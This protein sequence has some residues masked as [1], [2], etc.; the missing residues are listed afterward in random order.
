M[1]GSDR[2]ALRFGTYRTP[3]FRYGTVVMCEVRGEVTIVGLTNSRIP[4]PIGKRVRAKSHAVFGGLASAIHCESATAICYWFGVTPQTVTK[5]RKAMGVGPVNAGTSELKRRNWEEDWALAARRKALSKARDPERRR[6]IAESKRGKPR[7]RHVIEAMTA[8]R[9]GVPLSAAT[10][11][12]L[13][14]AHRRRGTRPPKAG[15][16]W[17]KWE[18]ALLRRERC[19]EVA[20][21]T[22][23]TLIA[24]YSRRA[25]LGITGRRRSRLKAPST[26]REL[27]DRS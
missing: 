6:K 21:S 17:K 8:A 9:L 11:A 10:R 26:S 15:R 13:S 24:V 7:P 20:R 27:N 2:C 22:G 4:W 25:L 12:K 23:R 19:P 14:A 16:P 18:D 5:W 1:T 3:R